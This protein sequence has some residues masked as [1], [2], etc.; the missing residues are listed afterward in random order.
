MDIKSFFT[1]NKWALLIGVAVYGMFLFFT[2]SGNRICDCASTEKS[3][4]NT[5]TNRVGVTRF[6]HK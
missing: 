4:P 1:N 2:F 6:Y 3:N 5:T